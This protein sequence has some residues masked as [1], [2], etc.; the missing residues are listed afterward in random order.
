M[1]PTPRYVGS[2]NVEFFVAS[3]PSEEQRPSGRCKKVKGRRP[4]AGQSAACEGQDMESSVD[5][6]RVVETFSHD[7]DALSTVLH[8]HDAQKNDVTTTTTTQQEEEEE[9]GFS[10]AAADF[11]HIDSGRKRCG[12]AA[13]LQSALGAVSQNLEASCYD[14]GEEGNECA[15]GLTLGLTLA[16]LAM[17]AQDEDIRSTT[18]IS[19][20][21]TDAKEGDS[22]SC[23]ESEQ[24]GLRA[25]LLLG[26][27]V[28]SCMGAA[29]LST[30]DAAGCE[31]D[32]EP[33]KSGLLRVE[34]WPQSPRTRARAYS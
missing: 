17:V 16:S 28:S 6:E 8:D 23:D 3:A 5:V 1:Q 13:A 27:V 25:G 10:S 22:S 18:D 12:D 7:H 26:L 31:T 11:S 15:I 24:A 4:A 30:G 2:K 33:R 20:H 32:T 34:D 9:E 19:A 29:Q 21:G 14:D